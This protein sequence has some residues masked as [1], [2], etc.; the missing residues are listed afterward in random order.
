ML[1]ANQR[2]QELKFEL[3]VPITST[4]NPTAFLSFNY[5]QDHFGGLY[6]IAIGQDVA[7]TGCVGFGMERVA[8]ALLKT[9][10]LD[11]KAWPRAVRAV[12]WP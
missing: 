9:H 2:E 1:A 11:P 10:G 4:E 6:G 8:L 3:V 7:H 5:H 12:L